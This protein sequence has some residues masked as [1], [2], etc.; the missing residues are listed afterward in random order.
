[1]VAKLKLKGIDGFYY[2]GG[3]VVAKLT[4]KGIDVQCRQQCLDRVQ[5]KH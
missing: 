5:I 4:L 1:M 3:S 2:F